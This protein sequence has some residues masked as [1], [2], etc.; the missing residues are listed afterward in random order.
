MDFNEN[1][2]FV[3]QDETQGYHWTHGCCTLHTVVL[4]VKDKNNVKSETFCFLSDD[5]EH[6]ILMVYYNQK[7]MMEYLKAN[8]PQ[9]TNVEYFIDERAVQYKIWKIFFNLCH[10]KKDFGGIEAKWIFFAMSYAKS[11]CDGVGTSVKRILSK[12][13]LQKPLHNQIKNVAMMY[14]FW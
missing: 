10:H 1:F 8:Y 13:S 9:V 4:Y 7:L 5:M 3:L 14:D 2:S 11:A 6:D 12:A